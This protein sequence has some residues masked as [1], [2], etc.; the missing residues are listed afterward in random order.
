MSGCDEANTDLGVGVGTELVLLVV[1][2][3]VGVEGRGYCV[4]VAED[5]VHLIVQL[6]D[7]AEVEGGLQ[8]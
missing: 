4:G 3:C 6:R 5:V 8:A 2:L 1:P 7:Q